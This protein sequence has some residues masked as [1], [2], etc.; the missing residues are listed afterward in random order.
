MK[1]KFKSLASVLCALIVLICYSPAGLAHSGRTDGQG[2]H[3]DNRN[4]SGLGSYHYHHGYSAHLH[5]GG[6][7]PYTDVFPRRVSVTAEKTALGYGESCAISAAVSPANSC[8]TRVTWKSSDSN[9]VQVSDGSIK[10]V[11]YG[12][13]TI[14]ATS[15]NDK[16][17]SV[18]IIVKE[19]V[20][21]SVTME[22]IEEGAN[23][24][25]IGDSKTI[26]AKVSPDNV[27]NPRIT[28]TSSDEA[29]ATVDNG[30]IQ[31]VAAGTAVITAA[32][33]NGVSAQVEVSV[34]EVIAEKVDIEGPGEIT[35]GDE[36]QLRAVVTP[37]N[38]TYPEV[39]WASDDESIATVSDDGKVSAV[40]VGKVTIS[41]V[42]KDIQTE[43]TIQV[44]SIPVENIEII[45]DDEFGGA[46]TEEETTQ[47]TA[48]VYP[49][50]ATYP[51]VAW[52]TSDESIA[53]VDNSGFLTAVS[54]GDVTIYA[55]T[56]DGAEETLEVHIRSKG[57][58][59][60]GAAVLGGGGYGIYRAVQAVRN[61]KKDSVE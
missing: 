2:G 61:K 33:A 4:A 54:K 41:A 24:V 3:R 36:T 19:I 20:A 30:R 47:L 15:F 32:A 39:E 11:G 38:T 17:G 6:Y 60:V 13:A 14:T 55:R 22:G 59:V 57:N 50:N 21:E 40:G 1:K 34:Q 56:T 16:V 26:S 58:P 49:E 25:F 48:T 42:Q 29:V 12:T 7:C 46:L 10:A 52:S 35:I 28:W 27:D 45:T 18:R 37:S 8:N 44:L 31:G 53:V 5:P 23:V 51:E 43:V 9:V